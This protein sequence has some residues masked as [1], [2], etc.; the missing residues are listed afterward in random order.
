MQPP[1]PSKAAS[2]VKKAA[3]SSEFK[4]PDVAKGSVDT[5]KELADKALPEALKS[6][7]PPPTPSKPLSLSFDAMLV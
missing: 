5:P 6:L 4:L 7:P 1:D 2:N 3:Q